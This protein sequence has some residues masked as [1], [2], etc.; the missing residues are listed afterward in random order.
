MGRRDEEESQTKHK[1]PP[2]KKK[3]IIN[4]FVLTNYSD[5]WEMPLRVV[6]IPS[7]TPFEKQSKTKLIFPVP[8]ISAANN[9][10]VRCGTLFSLP[11]QCGDFCLPW[12][13]EVLLCTKRL[14]S[15]TRNHRK[16]RNC[17][18]IFCSILKYEVTLI[19][20]YRYF[21]LKTLGKVDIGQMIK[22]IR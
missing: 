14:L 16:W 18:L 1:V 22:K 13:C 10:L 4:S 3:Q 6:D 8:E 15:K 20:G 19:Q 17:K 9:S 5:T 11:S 2:P 12:S 7:D 21:L